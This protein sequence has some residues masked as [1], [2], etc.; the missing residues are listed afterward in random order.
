[1]KRGLYLVSGDMCPGT[2]KILGGW[3]DRATPRNGHTG[4]AELENETW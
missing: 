1:M 2:S 4:Y 3:V